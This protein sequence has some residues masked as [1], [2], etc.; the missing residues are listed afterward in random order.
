MFA[1]GP[2][3]FKFGDWTVVAGNQPYLGK[4]VNGDKVVTADVYGQAWSL[5]TRN[6]GE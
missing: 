6:D 5:I 3:P 4:L 1:D 2:V